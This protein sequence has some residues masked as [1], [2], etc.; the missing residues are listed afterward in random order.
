[1]E[2]HDAGLGISVVMLLLLIC[3]FEIPKANEIF[4]FELQCNSNMNR[5]KYAS[6]LFF[7]RICGLGIIEA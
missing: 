3:A 4:I 7:M 6:A 5:C 1:M 2:I